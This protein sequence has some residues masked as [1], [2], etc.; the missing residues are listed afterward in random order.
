M[1]RISL[2]TACR[3]ARSA[4]SFITGGGGGSPPAIGVVRPLAGTS[5]YCEGMKVDSARE[6]RGG[7]RRLDCARRIGSEPAVELG[8]R[9]PSEGDERREGEVVGAGRSASVV[10][11][12]RSRR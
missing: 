11:S 7:S 12:S 6:D 5:P 3:F 1:T 2:T 10:R 9:L 8:R 4:R